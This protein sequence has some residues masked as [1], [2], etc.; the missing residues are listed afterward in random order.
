MYQVAPAPMLARG[1]SLPAPSGGLDAVSPLSA[2]PPTNAVT[3]VN[4]FPQPGYVE[5]RGGHKR[6]NLCGAA[7]I[8]TLMPYHAL[9]SDDD[10]M[11][12]ATT[13]DIYN[14]TA[15][16]TASASST[17]SVALSGFSSARFQH[18]NFS[19]SGGNYLWMCNGADKPQTYDGSSFATAS[20]SGVTATDIV[21]VAAFKKRIWLVLNGSISPAYLNTDSIQGTATPFDLTGVFQLGGYLQAIGSWSLDGGDGPDDYIAF[22]SSRGEVA[23]YAGTDPTSDFLIQGV[24]NMGAPLGRRCLTKVGADLAVVSI[25]GVLPLSRALVTD[26]AAAQLQAITRNIQPLVNAAARSYGDQ[27]GWELVP[28]PRGT[29]AILN[30]PMTENVEQFQYVMNTVTGAWTTFDG[31]KANC[32]AV[33]QDRLFYGGNDGIVLEADCQGFDDDGAIEFDGLT[34]FSYCDARGRL[35]Q[36]TMCR[37]LIA[38]DG[39][40]KP[41][42]GVAV[43]FADNAE[44]GPTTFEQSPASLWDVA[45]WDQDVWPIVNRTITDWTAVGGEGYAAAVRVSGQVLAESTAQQSDDFTLEINGFDLLVI[46]GAFM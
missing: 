40:I 14:V 30:V 5:I 43:D 34:A 19:T 29:R 6:H 12:A 4:I 28:Y 22:L 26:R 15:F 44:V 20:I 35:K 7:A 11:F 17:A 21:N 18:L 10:R 42:L 27:F 38:S 9:D 23:V 37:A 31:E 32:W 25:D 45:V 46:D 36:F 3:L 33:F 13:A 39:T 24:F 8:E 1:V 2:M 41:G 16:T